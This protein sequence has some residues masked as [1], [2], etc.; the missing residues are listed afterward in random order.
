[1]NTKT[2]RNVKMWVLAAVMGLAPWTVAAEPEFSKQSNVSVEMAD[3]VELAV[4]VYL[5]KTGKTFP[6]VL[7]RTPYDKRGMKFVVGAF[8]SKGYAV[9]LQDVRGQQ[10]SK[11]EFRPIV[12]EKKDGLDTLDW[13]AR[14]PWCDGN[15]GMWGSSYVAF[16]GLIVVPEKHP[17]LRTIVNISGW[18]N[19][20]AFTTP[21]G[22]MHMM[23]AL[24]WVLSNQIRG[25]GSF[26]DYNWPDVFRHLPVSEIP[27]AIG[28]DSA[29]W[30]HMIQGWNS[31]QLHTDGSIAGRYGDVAI[32]IFHIT[33]WNDF[34]ARHTLDVYEGIGGATAGGGKRP[35][36]KLMVGSWRHDQFW[37]TATVVGDEDFGPD[38]AMGSKRLLAL[39]ARWF[40]RWL[41]GI[42]NGVAKEKPV[43]LFLM[44]A[45][46]WHQYDQWP[47]R[48]VTNQRWYFDS[49]GGA[50]S[51]AGDGRLSTALPVQPG[52]DRFVYD[53]MKPVPTTGGANFHFFLDNLG[54]KDQRSL[55]QRK[56]VLVYTSAPFK[57]EMQVVGPLQAVVY[58]STEGKQ[59]DFTAKLVEVRQDGYARIIE[60]GIKRGSDAA[61]AGNREA[62]EPG[63][64]L[65]YTI[66][67]GGTGIVIP[68]GHRLRVEIASSNFP[69]YSRNPNTGEMAEWASEFKKVRQT[70]LHSEEYPS[71]IVLPVLR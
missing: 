3:G 16:C 43:N 4:D 25:K 18:G 22:A 37:T 42:D 15:I 2:M 26:R 1:M 56:D 27:S 40:D 70:V 29:Q 9:V 64:V 48:R 38:S 69:K 34:V 20:P 61:P 45:N 59:T 7:V 32:P 12:N 11:G 47:P 36:Q 39:S 51:A 57:R 13:I 33:G 24:P 66:D 35:F 17:N 14:Q 71:H 41:K 52:K 62:Q 54:P 67:M 68:K 58:A 44:N 10:A 30:Q 49:D 63:Q 5:P 55:E 8:V 53:P 60:E 31:R 46:E 21:G 19:T 23:C 6:V 50:N 65:R 28:A